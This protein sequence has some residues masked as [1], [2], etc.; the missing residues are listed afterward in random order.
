[1]T[2]GRAQRSDTTGAALD[3]LMHEQDAGVFPERNGRR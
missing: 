2:P 1:M 3:G